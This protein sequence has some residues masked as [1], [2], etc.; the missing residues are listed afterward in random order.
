MIFDSIFAGSSGGPR[1]R[2]KVDAG[3]RLGRDQ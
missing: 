3:T 2:R 1:L